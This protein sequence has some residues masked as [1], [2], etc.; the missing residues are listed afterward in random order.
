MGFYSENLVVVNR[1]DAERLGPKADDPVRIVSAT[2][3][4]GIWDLKNGT[5]KSIIGKVHITE[6]I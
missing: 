4:E 3:P 1:Q 6:T 5:R 2:N